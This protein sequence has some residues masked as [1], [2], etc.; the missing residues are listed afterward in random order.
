MAGEALYDQ[1]DRTSTDI[2]ILER[3]IAHGDIPAARKA[4]RHFLFSEAGSPEP[5]GS[6]GDALA[7][8]TSKPTRYQ[9]AATVLLRCLPVQGLVPESN[10]SN[11]IARNTVELCVNSV[12]DLM[13][14][15]KINPKA[16][17]FQVFS[18][19]SNA[20]TR[21]CQILAP[22]RDSYGDLQALI[23]GRKEI[24]GSLNHSLV[25]LY[26]GPFKIS[27]TRTTIEAI[28]GK[29]EKVR[30]LE[31]SVLKDIEECSRAIQSTMNDAQ[32]NP[33][34]I[35]NEFLI[36][37]LESCQSTLKDFFGSL[38][39]R[40][41]TNVTLIANVNGELQ[42]RYPLH[43]VERVITVNVPMRNS[44]P[45][46]A[47][48]VRVSSTSSSEDIIVE[49][50]TVNI[51]NVQPGDFSVQVD[52]IVAAPCG[53]FKA[54]VN[55]EWYELGNP[56]RKSE[57]FEIKV[58][59]QSS[60][61]DWSALEFRTPYSVDVAVG[62][63][64]VG[65]SEK[66]HS[67]AAKLLRQP[68]ESF[69][70]TGQKRVG[71]TSLTLAAAQYAKANSPEAIYNNKYILW[72]AIAHAEPVIAL[73]QLGEQIENLFFDSLESSVRPPKGDYN[74]SLSGL[75]SLSEFAL[76]AAPD[77]RYIIIIDEF[78]E[79]HQ[80]L[81]LQGNLAET[82]FANLR[83]LSRCKNVC[84]VLIGGENM[85]FVMERQG[86]KLNNFSRFNLSY[87]LRDTEWS[88]F[89]L[90][91]RKP[92]E[93]TL[94]W[95]EDAVSEVFN[96]TQG[97]PYFSKVVCSGVYNSCIRERDA[98]VTATEVK[99]AIDVEI[100]KI[101]ENY[102]AH[103]WQDGIPKGATEREPDILR[104]M[105]VLVAIARCLRQKA[106]PIATNISLHKASASISETE[107]IAVLND[108]VRRGVLRDDSRRYDFGLPI[109]K[110]WLIDVGVSQLISDKLYE[111]L[112]DTAIAAENAA[113]VRSEEIVALARQWPT[114]RGRHI[115][116]DD[117][118]SWLQQ[119]DS[120]LDQRI[121]FEILQR[122]KIYSEDFVRERLRSA[123]SLLRAS[124][125]PFIQRK[126]NER[127][128]DIV[129]TYIDGE[130]KSGASYASMYAEENDIAAECVVSSDSFAKKFRMLS[131]KSQK[132][133]ALVIM[134]DIAATGSSLA[135]NI[136]KFVAENGH[137][138]GSIPIKIVT[139]TATA[140]AQATISR[141]LEKMNFDIEF[142]TCEIL[143]REL[144]VF[145]EG[146]GVW[147]SDDDAGRAKA[148]CENLGSRIYRQAP[149]GFGG[150]GLLVVFPTTVPNNSLPILHSYAKPSS[151]KTWTPLF[152]R[153]IN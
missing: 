54:I 143:A 146:G 113:L 130:G 132:P 131:E 35:H 125:P 47:I 120:I 89:Q 121:L 100:S 29:L 152:P 109:F 11:M 9:S 45:G 141:R 51:G 4:L 137:I 84:I 19:L 13:S 133:A 25:R 122:T 37:L 106:D 27:E 18:E 148:L 139:L 108:F 140:N 22:L 88:D 28:L 61:I 96:I 104:R 144:Y 58:V 92:T 10:S 36:P 74:G 3:C 83:A 24:I 114:Y 62:D 5:E 153:V 55:V 1:G 66:V 14:F 90:L 34:F 102:F 97:N 110:L 32:Q 115:G 20:H 127:R 33:S 136:E 23:G 78:D 98:D 107:I 69:Y 16:Q 112:A 67:L 70:V 56:T 52:A 43:E 94:N 147:K 46:M 86:Q 135:D 145:P 105:R 76:K 91:V 77:Q 17:T 15:L 2:E 81:F 79:I 80:E 64:F 60:T 6:I 48:D 128:S 151:G 129:L 134:D 75:I 50:A 40:F 41:S 39:D 31:T 99:R 142:R 95:H 103:L 42:K 101:G 38:H 111:E 93:G 73:K 63:E 21:V 87:Y 72:G 126:K 71:K 44:G 82:F 118:R 85:P 119:V 150:L 138:V 53:I 57:I 59:A 116:T 65:R 26:G 49:T 117:I 149:Y 8:L 30:S 12:P 7:K 124:F 123:H 68:M